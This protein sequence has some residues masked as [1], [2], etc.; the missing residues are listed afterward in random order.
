MVIVP[1]ERPV[2]TGLNSFYLDIERLLEHYQ[3]EIG[4]GAIHFLSPNAEAVFFFDKDDILGGAYQG[5][6]E[7]GNGKQAWTNMLKVSKVGSFAV[8]I[9][10][11]DPEKVYFWA[12]IPSGQEIYR[13]LSTEFTDL[14]RLI[15]KMASEKLTGYINVSIGNG[16]EGGLI[17][18]SNGEIV[19]GSYSWG[20]GEINGS[21]ENLSLLIQRTEVSSGVFHVTRIPVKPQP[22]EKATPK[23][24]GQP[25]DVLDWLA[26]L[27][28]DFD[29]LFSE[30]KIKVDFRRLL[31]HKF[32]E[33]ADKFPFLDP[34][35]AEF[36]YAEGRI[37]FTGQAGHDE[38]LGAVVQCAREMA[39]E[40][41]ISPS[42]QTLLDAWRDS[43]EEG[44]AG[45]D[46]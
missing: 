29:Q 14:E 7:E 38:L 13:D 11:I 34:F 1:R 17:F 27:L 31:R 18:L 22:G 15:K 32:I 44:L 36:E 3:G 43:H 9:Y 39:A 20:H 40:T 24:H 33:K 12:N 4:A 26:A 41:G 45:L 16:D 21:L 2:M 6:E 35:E 19:G 25:P 23:A 8:D 5:R 30:R 42:F 37:T 10:E 46:L 28:K